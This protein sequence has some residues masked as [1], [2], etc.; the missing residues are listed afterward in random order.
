MFSYRVAN[1]V[2]SFL[3]RPP[4][5]HAEVSEPP[6]T[7]TRAESRGPRGGNPLDPPSNFRLS[8]SIGSMEDSVAGSRGRMLIRKQGS[9]HPEYRN[10]GKTGIDAKT[11]TRIFLQGHLP[12]FRAGASPV[13]QIPC[14]AVSWPSPSFRCPKSSSSAPGCGC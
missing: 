5:I 4:R 13:G 9:R 11:A 2:H 1:Y 12:N 10:D 7:M 3:S 14:R 8:K 6:A